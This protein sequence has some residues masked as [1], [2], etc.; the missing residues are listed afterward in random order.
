M[1]GLV[2]KMLLAGSAGILELADVFAGGFSDD[3]GSA[4]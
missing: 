1:M 4:G 3:F 2:Q